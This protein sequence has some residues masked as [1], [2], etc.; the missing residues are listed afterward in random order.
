MLSSSCELHKDVYR[1]RVLCKEDQS[2]WFCYHHWIRYRKKFSSMLL[3][4]SARISA[5][6]KIIWYWSQRGYHRHTT[7]I[8]R[9]HLMWSTR[10]IVIGAQ[11]CMM[12]EQEWGALSLRPW[13][14]C[15]VEE[16]VVWLAATE[17]RGLGGWCAITPVSIT[18]HTRLVISYFV[19]EAFIFHWAG[20]AV[21]IVSC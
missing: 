3:I 9:V 12:Q 13:E 11:V 14:G 18:P 4:R 5:G 1:C 15:W 20:V 17:V 21:L 10:I 2:S 16:I 8:L 19:I 7:C 6:C